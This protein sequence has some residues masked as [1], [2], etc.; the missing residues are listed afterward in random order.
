MRLA[1]RYDMR[2]PAFGAS[3]PALYA[4]SVEQSR[5]ADQLGFDTVYL[6]EH[7]GAEDG[8]CA[9]PMIQAS[10][11][12]AVTSRMQIHLSA[13][14]AVLHHPLR[15]AEDLA[16]VDIISQG[17]LAMTLGIGYRP[18]EYAMFGV[19]KSKRVP[20]LEEIIDV[21]NQAWTGEAFDYHGTTVMVRPTPVQ[22][23]RPPIY[24][25]GSSEASAIRAARF[26]DNYLPAVPT[27]TDVYEAELRRLGK[28]VPPRPLPK[29]PLFLFVSDD[30]ERDWP[31][32]APHVIYTSNSNAQWAR[33]RGVGATPYPPVSDIADLKASPE[34]AVV[35]PDECVKLAAEL[36][37]DS[38]L[39]FQPLMGGLDPAVGWRSL[40]MFEA[41]VLPRLVELDLR[42]DRTRR[43]NGADTRGARI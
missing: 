1:L 5:W 26:G 27:L 28:P 33:E 7:H 40:E 11:I 23:P 22:K 35:T 24:I 25:G 6:A 16:T 37:P 12:A 4:A 9:S 38:E 43:T 15:L 30:P 14:I 36:G 31:V 10:A 2:A 8:Y 21:L 19:E 29:G 18:H 34:F 13:L 3:T 32:V 17:R 20:L 39:V 42:G 41:E